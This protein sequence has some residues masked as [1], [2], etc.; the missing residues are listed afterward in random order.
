MSAV[1]STHINNNK[2]KTMIKRVLEIGDGSGS[3]TLCSVSI[4]HNELIP[5]ERRTVRTQRIQIDQKSEC[6]NCEE[7]CPPVELTVGQIDS[8]CEALQDMKLVLEQ[9]LAE[10]QGGEE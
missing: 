10:A 5:W 3:Y 2:G 4:D 1:G 7:S 8:L 9:R 6:W